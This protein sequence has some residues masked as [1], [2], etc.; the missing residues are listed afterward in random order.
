MIKVLQVITSLEGGGGVQMLLKNY[1]KYIDKDKII[2]DFIVYGDKIGELESYFESYGSKVYHIPPK[3]KSLIKSLYQMRKII[4]NGGY[5]VVHVHQDIMSVFPIYFAKKA[6]VDLRIA[7]AHN[8]FKSSNKIK[9]FIHKVLIV[10]LKK[11]SNYW[12]ACGKEAAVDLWGKENVSLGNINIINNAIDVNKFI[13]NEGIRTE[14]RKELM[15]ENKFVIGNIG[16]LSEQKNHKFIIDIFKNINDIDKETILLLVG[17]GEL[18]SE[19]REEVKKLGLENNVRFLGLRN[20]IDKILQGID[21]FLLPSKF[22]GLP[23]ALVEAQSSDLPCVVSDVVTKEVKIT[24]KVEYMSLDKDAKA[25]AKKIL[26]YKN[27]KRYDTSKL[28]KKVGFDISEQAKSLENLYK[29][30]RSYR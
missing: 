16:R 24:D 22:E 29:S 9:I 18:E 15:V 12:S 14:I 19:V 21:V 7:H 26:S 23:I 5:N 30:H 3:T 1:H 20:D 10:F 17:K 8:A 4:K 13:F 28:I 11:Y 6:K 27:N 2:F 25:W